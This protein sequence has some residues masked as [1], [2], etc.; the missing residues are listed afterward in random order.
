VRNE[1]NFHTGRNSQGPG[2]LPVPPTGPIV[3]NEANLPR[4]N[5]SGRRQQGRQCCYCRGQVCKTKPIC[6]RRAEAADVGPTV[7]C[8]PHLFLLHHLLLVV[9]RGEAGY[10]AS[11]SD[12]M[13]HR[14]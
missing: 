13:T 1:A 4:I 2:R 9:W 11:V 3:R 10:N 14:I 12:I 8:R 6:P 5:R 7:V